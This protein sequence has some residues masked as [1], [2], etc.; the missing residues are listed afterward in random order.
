[1]GVRR[2]KSY[3]VYSFDELNEIIPSVEN[4]CKQFNARAYLRLNKQNAVDVITNVKNTL[5]KTRSR[6]F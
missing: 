3:C 6:S 1:M 4:Y 5:K 2:L